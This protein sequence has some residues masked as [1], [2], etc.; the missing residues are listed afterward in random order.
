MESPDRPARK[1]IQKSLSLLLVALLIA[2]VYG[3]IR[4]GRGT[5]GSPAAAPSPSTTPDQAPLV[6]QTPLL[7]AQA[8]AH[9]PTPAA[10]LPFAQ[11]ALQL[12][13]QEMDLAFALAV[14][15]A[16]Q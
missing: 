4:T 9:M 12:G 11:Q 1:P 3:L 8:L 15:D 10:E 16:T 5:G 6:D 2:T 14:L 13:D 7:T